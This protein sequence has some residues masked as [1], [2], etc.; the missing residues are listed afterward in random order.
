MY[1]F[2][3]RLKKEIRLLVILLKKMKEN[4]FDTGFLS[5]QDKMMLKHL[6]FVIQNYERM[7]AHFPPEFSGEMAE[8]SLAMIH[9]MTT[10]LMEELGESGISLTEEEQYIFDEVHNLIDN[11]QDRI[12]IDKS[13]PVPTIDQLLN[14][15]DSDVPMKHRI[16]M[17]I[18]EI[19]QQITP[20][21]DGDKADELLDRR[22]ELL[23][24]LRNFS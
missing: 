23:E 12:R 2:E 19:D 5:D 20:D 18:Q 14:K 7:E 24:Q 17:A 10:M 22:L 3:E 9:Q 21:I 16:M 13:L 6:D 11:E 15:T 8:S 4:E 1:S